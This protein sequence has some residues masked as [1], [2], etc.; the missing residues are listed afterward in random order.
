MEVSV[1]GLALVL[2]VSAHGQPDAPCG[3]VN[4]Q[5][6]LLSQVLVSGWSGPCME[7]L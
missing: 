2:S 1:T 7:Y 3:R 5:P 6:P 4:F